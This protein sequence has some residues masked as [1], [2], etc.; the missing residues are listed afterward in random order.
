MAA[1]T[2]TGGPQNAVNRDAYYMGRRAGAHAA[3]TVKPRPGGMDELDGF[4]THR[5]RIPEHFGRNSVLQPPVAAVAE[6]PVLFVIPSVYGA[7]PWDWAL[8]DGVSELRCPAKGLFDVVDELQ[9]FLGV[10]EQRVFQHL[11]A[12]ETMHMRT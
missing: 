12:P 4:P 2:T 5:R 6:P 11:Q 1:Q 8:V 9:A 7:L 3:L 10:P